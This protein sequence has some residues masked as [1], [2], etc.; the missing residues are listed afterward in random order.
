MPTSILISFEE[1]KHLFVVR[2][3]NTI[4]IDVAISVS[5]RGTE[6]CV[7]F[8]FCWTLAYFDHCL[9]QFI[10][11][12]VSIT[13]HIKFFKNSPQ[14]FFFQLIVLEEEIFSSKIFRF[15]VFKSI[16]K[17]YSIFKQNCNQQIQMMSSFLLEPYHRYSNKS[18]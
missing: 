6:H 8:I 7:Q 2:T 13:V 10:F 14:I 3:R 16:K 5:V 9:V 17:L 12:Y 15:M 11:L 18:K 1:K 4:E